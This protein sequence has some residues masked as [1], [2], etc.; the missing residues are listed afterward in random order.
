MFTVNFYGCI[1]NSIFGAFIILVIL[2]LKKSLFKRFS[3]KFNY[4]IWI[5]L[6]VCIMFPIK[7]NIAE[8]SIPKSISNLKSFDLNLPA[9]K[10]HNEYNFLSNFSYYKDTLLYIHLGISMIIFLYYIL[11]F[12]YD[13][14]ELNIYSYKVKNEHI[15][16]IYNNV[17]E[18]LNIKK[19]LPLRVSDCISTPINVGVIHSN[20]II[21]NINYSDKELELIFRHDFI[22]GKRHDFFTKTFTQLVVSFNWFNPLFY[23]MKKDIFNFCELSCDEAVIKLSNKQ[24]IK[25][26][27][28][29]LIKTS[30][31]MYKRDVS[32]LST[33]TNSSLIKTRIYSIADENKKSSGNISLFVFSLLFF[34]IFLTIN[35]KFYSIPNIVDSS[36]FNISENNYTDEDANINGNDNLALNTESDE[37]LNYKYEDYVFNFIG[38]SLQNK[39]IDSL[40]SFL[41]DNNINYDTSNDYLIVNNEYILLKLNLSNLDNYILYQKK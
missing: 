5:P 36:Y 16:K 37:V 33:L 39:D 27:G 30:G 26:Y 2:L 28:N 24:D 32:L 31:N 10:I 21:P 17:A 20:I 35:I 11:K 9:T 29:M 14:K 22:H 38:V 18:E 19:R 40:K 25:V 4:F 8:N 15:N 23:I 7:V 41:N 3:N 13:R 12:I 6:L 1:K 34:I